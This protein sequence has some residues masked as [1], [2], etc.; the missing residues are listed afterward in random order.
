MIKLEPIVD[1]LIPI[2]FKSR[3][4]KIKGRFFPTTGPGSCPTVILL[5]GFPRNE[6][7]LFGL[8]QEMSEKG[9]NVF[10]FNYSGTWESEGVFT[11]KTSLQ[12]VESA[13]S[14][15][16]SSEMVQKFKIDT[17]NI[18]II[19]YSYGGGFALL[20]SLTDP[21]VRKVVSIAGGDLS[22]LARMIEQ[23]EEYRKFH[24]AFLDEYMS[25]STVTRGLGGRTTHE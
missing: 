20:G 7:D 17:T 19:G 18:S 21:K 23:N 2:T 15:L 24:E 10:T 11:P 16:K 5:H 4:A 8:G 9:I 1:T 14:F 12:D 25:D 3:G 22:V 6:E 13:I